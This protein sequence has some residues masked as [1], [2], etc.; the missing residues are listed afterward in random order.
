MGLHLNLLPGVHSQNNHTTAAYQTIHLKGRG[1]ILLPDAYANYLTGQKLIIRPN[2]ILDGEKKAYREKVP[3]L[4]IETYKVFLD[5]LAFFPRSQKDQVEKLSY[6]TTKDKN[7][8]TLPGVKE[9][10]EFFGINPQKKLVAL[11]LDKRI[12]IWEEDALIAH[13]Q[14]LRPEAMRAGLIQARS[15]RL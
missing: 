6:I 5:F 13:R 4:V 14:A 1:A 12:E 7:K 11:R 2:F 9:L 8:I 15:N 10:L 3:A